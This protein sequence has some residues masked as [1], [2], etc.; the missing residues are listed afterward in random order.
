[1]DETTKTF[2]G[3]IRKYLAAMEAGN[4][5]LDSAAS[6]GAMEKVRHAA[7]QAFRE[8]HDFVAG[9]SGSHKP[10]RSQPAAE[11]DAEAAHSQQ[12]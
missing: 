5:E 6:E 11:R 10:Q 12:Q 3:R 4:G 1:M 7:R 9:G 2:I 8:V